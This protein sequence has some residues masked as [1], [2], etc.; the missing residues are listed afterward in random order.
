MD[1]VGDRWGRMGTMSDSPRQPVPGQDPSSDQPREDQRIVVL[2][3]E[4]WFALW[5][6]AQ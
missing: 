5:R 4:Q 6:E 1:D 3:P 2:T